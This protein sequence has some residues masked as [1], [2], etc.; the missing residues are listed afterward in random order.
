MDS[1]FRFLPTEEELVS[2]Y[3]REKKQVD[4]IIPEIDICKH[5]P[6]DVPGLYAGLFTEPESPYQDMFFFSPRVYEYN[7]SARIERTTAL[8]FWKIT[9]K[10]R[11]IK[12]R[13]STGRKKTLTFYEGRVRQ[14]K[15]TNWVMY[16]Y[17]LVEDEANPNP[18]LAQQR[19]FVLCRLKKKA[20]DKKH[21]SIY[22]EAEPAC[23]E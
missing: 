20:D 13:G 6:W 12:A 18:T 8:G 2:H 4:H 15:K 7:N 21:T 16:E 3:L 9:G 5:E 10:E 22:A 11:V 19:D 17:Y 14:S 1:Y 23:D